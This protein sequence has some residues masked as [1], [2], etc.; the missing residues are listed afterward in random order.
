MFVK[1]EET[2][3]GEQPPGAPSPATASPIDPPPGG[4]NA[5]NE[6]LAGDTHQSD[7][8]GSYSSWPRV[9]DGHPDQQSRSVL[10]RVRGK[11]RIPLT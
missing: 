3:S 10:F 1:L 7:V 9:H 4:M 2:R 8:G 5:G 11:Y 6:D